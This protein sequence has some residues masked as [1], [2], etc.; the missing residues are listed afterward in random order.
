MNEKTLTKRK[1]ASYDVKSNIIGA[2]MILP[3]FVLFLLLSVYPL[4]WALRFMFY[5]YDGITQATFCGLDNFIKA[6]TRETIFWK[7]VR[8]TFYFTFVKLLFEIPLAVVLGTLLNSK[9]IKFK[10]FY[11]GLYFLPCV[12]SSAI[13]TLIFSFILSPYNGA[14]N[15]LLLNLNIIN[16]RIEWLSSPVMAMHWCIF[17]AVWQNFGQ[18][19]I[20][21]IS[22]L[23]NIP[24]ELYESADIDGAT[25]VQS[26]FKITL[27]ML[28]PLLKTI[29]MLA[30]IG[31]LGSFESVFI[32]TGGG[33]NHATELMTISVYNHFFTADTAADFGYG[34]TLGFISSVLICIF[35][36]GYAAVT[37][38]M[39]KIYE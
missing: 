29:L 33:P 19:C 36:V 15:N 30:I 34:A 3:G 24:A 21:V 38:R 8:N 5:D 37:K 20:L 14:L 6:F 31:S 13:L 22:G 4:A 7:S 1:P 9:I 28:S 27:P 35:T 26:F 39:N 10:N 11:R 12:L 32:L 18:N 23:Q 16:H 25:S 17:L 2:L